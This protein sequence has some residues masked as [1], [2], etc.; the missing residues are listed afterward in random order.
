MKC[1]YCQ[2]SNGQHNGACPAKPR[3]NSDECFDTIS[4]VKAAFDGMRAQLDAIERRTL[5]RLL[6]GKS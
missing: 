1:P 2:T 3:P 4:E 6:R 5:Q